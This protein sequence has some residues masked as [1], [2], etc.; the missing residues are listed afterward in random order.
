MKVRSVILRWVA[1]PLTIVGALA[2]GQAPAFAASGGGCRSYPDTSGVTAGVS[3]C[4]SAPEYGVAAADTYVTLRKGHPDCT[5]FVYT[6][7]AARGVTRSWGS[8][9]CAASGT[10][11]VVAPRVR[12]LKGLYMARVQVRGLYYS[13]ILTLP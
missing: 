3:A 13:P 8:A 10:Q 4:I 5:I 2:F 7:D 9:K 6:Y 12:G 11:H 1:A